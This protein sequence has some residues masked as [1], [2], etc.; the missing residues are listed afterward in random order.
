MR[1]SEVLQAQHTL[2]VDSFKYDPLLL[3]DE[4]RVEFIRWNVLALEDELHEMLDE[5]GW[6][7][8]A[9]S[10]HVN[11]DAAMK[12]L[13]DAFHFFMNLMMAV[14]PRGT[15]PEEIARDFVLAYHAKRE[16]NAERQVEGY[17]GINGKCPSCHR[18]LKEVPIITLSDNGTTRHACACGKVLD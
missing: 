10:R 13:V 4:Q 12:E 18:D 14:A 2:Q 3:T 17:D 1:F 6:K 9:S 7:P 5:V 11:E 16:R 15:V 8:W